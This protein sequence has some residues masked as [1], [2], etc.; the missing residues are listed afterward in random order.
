MRILSE[1]GRFCSARGVE[2]EG[3][4]QDQCQPEP[5]SGADRNAAG[6][7]LHVLHSRL[8]ASC[9]S[10]SKHLHVFF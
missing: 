2:R 8:L 4:E 3:E 9:V 5:T 10:P 6:T 7:G 1:L